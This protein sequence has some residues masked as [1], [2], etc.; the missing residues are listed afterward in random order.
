MTRERIELFN[1]LSANRMQPEDVNRC[2]KMPQG[3]FLSVLSDGAGAQLEKTLSRVE[4]AELAGMS[5]KSVYSYFASP[6]ARD[7]RALTDDAR[8][9]VIWHVIT[10]TSSMSKPVNRP[11]HGARYIVN[12]ET[13][14]LREAARALG[15][16][17][18]ESLSKRI[19]LAGLKP[20]GDISHLTNPR[21]G[22]TKP[23]VYIVNGESMSINRAS[24]VLGY[25]TSQV[26]TKKIRIMGVPEGGDISHL[27]QG[28]ASRGK[29]TSRADALEYIA[30][31][32]IE[33][34]ECGKKY[35]CLDKH[36][37]TRHHMTSDE[38]REKYNI[39]V[40]IPLAGAG[41]R[42]KHRQKMQGLQESGSI[43]YT[44]LDRA[45]DA[46]RDAGRGVKRDFDREKQ[47]EIMRNINA[48]GKAYRKS[49]NK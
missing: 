46:A 14:L 33:C 48:S 13:M 39:P 1:R 30:G 22:A 35:V 21:P 6:S 4:F 45:T 24:V 42:E 19:A 11:R 34:L 29:M 12:G 23:H 41:Y 31:D 43:D 36:L 16:A 47:A 7:Y 25:K 40:S 3:D 8:I 20:G 15:Y 27:T 44:H 17:R 18:R 10:K 26:L 5:K 2:L 9:A 37:R 49:K 28:S 32:R 38:Y